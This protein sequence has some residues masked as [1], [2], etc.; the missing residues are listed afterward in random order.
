MTINIPKKSVIK[1]ILKQKEPKYIYNIQ[2][3]LEYK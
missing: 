1:L 2:Y 3:N